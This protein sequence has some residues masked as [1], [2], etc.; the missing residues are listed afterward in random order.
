MKRTL[1]LLLGMMICA[2]VARGGDVKI[3]VVTSAGAKEKPTTVFTPDTP[4]IWATFKTK[5]AKKGD[6]LRGEW[7][8]DDVGE[9][10]P[11]NTKIDE[12]IAD[13]G[14]RHRRRKF[15]VLKPTKGWPAGKYHLDI[16]ANDE[17]ATTVKF[18]IEAAKKTTEKPTEK[19]R[20]R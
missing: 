2:S 7:I 20:G 15:H 8:A 5:G 17:L 10:A 16:Y 13:P 12:K 9:A 18:T 19:R 6:K 11:A 14:R 3:T 4:E 1:A